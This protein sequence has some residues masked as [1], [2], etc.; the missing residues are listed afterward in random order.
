[1][2][3]YRRRSGSALCVALFACGGQDPILERAEQIREQGG[4]SASQTPGPSSAQTPPPADRVVVQPEPGVPDAP[5]PVQPETDSQNSPMP[6][7]P[8]PGVPSDP[9]PGPG[10]ARGPTVS[11]SGS[12]SVVGEFS[13]TVL[14]RPHAS[15]PLV[16]PHDILGPG[17]TVEFPDQTDFVIDVPMGEPVFLEAFMDFEER[18]GRPNEGEPMMTSSEGI[19]TDADVSDLIIVLEEQPHRPAPEGAPSLDEP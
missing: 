12:L 17:I 18:N 3:Q 11:L 13:G 9:P 10:G 15:D 5:D 19:A 16:P 8:T 2:R 7:E 14:I 1:M 6:S 4:P